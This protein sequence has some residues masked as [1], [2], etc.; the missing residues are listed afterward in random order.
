MNT[1]TMIS[2]NCTLSTAPTA[3]AAIAGMQGRMPE[4]NDTKASELLEELETRGQTS[5]RSGDRAVSVYL[6]IE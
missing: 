3:E 1:Y 2:P 5:Y 6:T 4:I